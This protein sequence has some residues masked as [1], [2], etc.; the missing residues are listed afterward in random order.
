[1]SK[2]IRLSDLGMVEKNI[3]DAIS[4]HRKAKEEVLYWEA[5]LRVLNLQKTACNVLSDTPLF[6]ETFGG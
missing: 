5:R 1:M 4:A 3:R 6:E 2:E